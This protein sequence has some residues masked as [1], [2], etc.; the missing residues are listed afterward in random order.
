MKNILNDVS[1]TA[2]ITLR[3]RVVASQMEHPIIQDDMGAQVLR[4]IRALI[5]EE[6]QKRL[7]DSKV[8][9]MLVNH[10][11]IRARK[12]DLYTKEFLDRNP[13]GLV[14]SLGCGLD[15]RYW[16]ISDRDWK[17][18][19]VDL[20]E[21]VIAKKEILGEQLNY[22]VIGCSVLDDT[23]VKE[24]LAIQHENILFIAEGL[25]M[26]LPQKE[27]EEIFKKLSEIFSRSQIV[28][29]VIIKKYTTGFWKKLVETKMKRQ[30]ST[31]AGSSYQFGVENAAEVET[32]G[33]NIKVVEEWSYF[34][35]EDIKPKIYGLFK[36]FKFLAR[37]QWTIYAMIGWE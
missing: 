14:V 5:P 7:L 18:V 30:L 28:F 35:D 20:P 26:Y 31:A 6:T 17:Y 22:P 24:I 32:Y 21:V 11:A 3:S 33:D 2:L 29:E 25:F 15:T 8:P 12:Y 4:K 16:R 1:E 13:D 10:I 9:A 37:T 34:E 19:E 27:V 36:N 23:W